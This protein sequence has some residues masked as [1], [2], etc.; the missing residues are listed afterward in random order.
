MLA[1]QSFLGPNRDA[2]GELTVSVTLEGEDLEVFLDS[3]STGGAT[4]RVFLT[5][6]NLV[7]RAETREFARIASSLLC[8]VIFP[9]HP[10][11]CDTSS[12]SLFRRESHCLV[13]RNCH[14]EILL[15]GVQN[16]GC[17]SPMGRDAACR[18]LRNA[19]I[20]PCVSKHSLRPLDTRFGLRRGVACHGGWHD[21][22]DCDGP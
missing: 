16:C 6:Q 5:G 17:A 12:G 13:L 8:F 19:L 2:V 20:D 14:G 1:D 15:R 18:A 9:G 22:L 11:G 3:D 21:M 4:I 7:E 10:G